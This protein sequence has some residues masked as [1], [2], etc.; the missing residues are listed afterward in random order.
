MRIAGQSREEAGCCP[1]HVFLI[2][3]VRRPP[4]AHTYTK[5][6]WRSKGEQCTGMFYPHTF[7]VESILSKRCMH[8]H[9]RI[10]R[11]TKYGLWA[12]QIKMTDQRK[13]E[14]NAL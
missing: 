8:R 1:D 2:P 9:G 14:R 5:A 11:Y 10:L 7:G 4:Q 12:R 6:P 13:T 3:K